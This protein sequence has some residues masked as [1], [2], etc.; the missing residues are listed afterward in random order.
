MMTHSLSQR[1]TRRVKARTASMSHGTSRPSRRPMGMA[2]MLV[3]LMNRTDKVR[4]VAPGTDLTFSI[5]G[6]PAVKCSGRRN[7]PDGEVYTAPV[8][9]SVNGRITYNVPSKYNGKKFENISLV[10][11]DGKIV[12]A[13]ANDSEAVNRVFDTDEGARYVGEFSFGVNP[14]IHDAMG[15]I[16]FDEKIAGSIH[17]TPGSCYE[18]APNGNDSAI[19]WDLVLDMSADKGGGEIY[20][21]DVLVR[22]D[23]IFV[24]D[25]LKGLNPDALGRE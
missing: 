25:E 6:I 3:E 16:L 18:E 7:I 5:K 22:K 19:H 12:E 20:M 21:D 8:R 2:A 23:G 4:L 10:F 24:L 1:L 11:K 15:D 13:T 17:F 9:D 14:F